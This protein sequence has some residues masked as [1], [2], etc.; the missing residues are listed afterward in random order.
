MNI[1]IISCGPMCANCY[2]VEGKS[3]A[4]I[5]DPGFSEPELISTVN[6][7]KGKIKY[8]MLTHR[9]FDHVSAAVLLR[10][11]T[12]AEI[13]IHEHDECGLYSDEC[14]LGNLCNGLYGHANSGQRADILIVDGDI[15]TAGDLVFKVISTPGHSPGGVCFLIG[16]TLFSGD[17]L[18]NGSIGRTDFP[19]SNHDDMLSSLK[20]LSKLPDNTVVYPGH[21]SK[22]TIGEER[23]LNP[24][25]YDL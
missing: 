10:E 12:G 25:F 2:I 8:I 24:F 13:I 22:S 16:N 23:Q 5:I 21:G 15:I 7:L 14:S 17:T 6:Q 4:V 9:H 20:I 19:F 18:F 3:G 11:I 1:Q